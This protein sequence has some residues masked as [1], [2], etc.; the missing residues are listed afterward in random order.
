MPRKLRVEYPGALYH[1]MSRNDPDQLTIAARRGRETLLSPKAIALRVH[2][3]A[4]KCASV[5]LPAWMKLHPAATT[6]VP[7]GSGK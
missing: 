6:R 1:L 5:R 3:G 2:W 4:S 7:G